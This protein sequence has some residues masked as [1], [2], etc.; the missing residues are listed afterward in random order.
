MRNRSI[1]GAI[2]ASVVLALAG[3]PVAGTGVTVTGTISGNYV[4]IT[5]DVTV[6]ITNGSSS[7]T[8][9]IPLVGNFF[10]VGSFLVAD[11]PPGTYEVTVA[12][13]ADIASLYIA[14]YQVNDGGWLDVDGVTSTGDVSPYSF[15]VT[16]D[17]V[18]VTTD[19][20]IDLA[21]S[22]NVG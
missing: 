18:S 21:F 22:D 17:N 1:L 16:I 15:T 10:Q 11:V 4:D 8:A 5:G 19:I 3:C 20:T 9:T 7:S 13:A 2:L 6:T 12:F 14:E